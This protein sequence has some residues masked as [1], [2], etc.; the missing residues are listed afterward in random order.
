M[1]P[2]VDYRL[3]HLPVPFESLVLVSVVEQRISLA[4]VL[5][6]AHRFR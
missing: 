6:A 2:I 5:D 3:L 1:I 4:D